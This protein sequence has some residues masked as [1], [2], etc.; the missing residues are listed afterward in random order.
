M[1]KIGQKF[2][3]MALTA[4][5]T[6]KVR[7]DIQK[8][9]EIDDAEIFLSSFDRSNI[10]YE[11]REKNENIDKEIVRF[12]KKHPGKSGI[13]YCRNRK[14]VESLA[15]FLRANDIKALAY[16]AG[17]PVGIRTANQDDFL[18]EEADVII[19]T[20]AFGMG[21]DKPDVRFVIHYD[22]PKS[23][24]GYYQETGRAGRDDGEAICIAFYAYADILKI[25]KL[26]K[27][28]SV[29]EQDIARQLLAETAV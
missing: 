27:K 7:Y 16:H 12:I 18:K 5:A 11:V 22:I 20:I 17:M 19:A 15:E 24:E 10:Y 1:A 13:V 3:I 25:E 6:P 14:K 4:T 2:P 21:I 8:N 28:K 9:L 23:I 26:I 29:L